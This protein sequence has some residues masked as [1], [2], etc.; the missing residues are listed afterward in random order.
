MEQH[1]VLV[2][3]VAVEQMG[4]G[5]C[6]PDGVLPA[7]YTAVV[8]SQCCVH[9]VCIQQPEALMGPLGGVKAPRT[10]AQLPNDEVRGLRCHAAKQLRARHLPCSCVCCQHPRLIGQPL[11][12]QGLFPPSVLGAV[13]KSPADVVT[14]APEGHVV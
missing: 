3:L 7:K 8:L 6:F 9:E 13:E 4:D 2:W 10:V 1:T 5:W 14:Y 12:G 11:L